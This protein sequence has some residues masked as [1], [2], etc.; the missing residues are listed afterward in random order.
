MNIKNK[1]SRLLQAPKWLALQTHIAQCGLELFLSNSCSDQEA[2]LATN[3]MR[4]MGN[5]KKNM[6]LCQIPDMKNISSIAPCHTF[7]QISST[8]QAQSSKA[9]DL[10]PWV[11][12]KTRSFEGGSINQTLPMLS[13]MI[14][15]LKCCT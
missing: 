12:T 9:L 3:W 13:I 5:K 4:P 14:D 7:R 6:H 10:R 1:S 2:W 8:K 15:P 11:L